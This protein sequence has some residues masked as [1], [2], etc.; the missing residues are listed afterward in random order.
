[1]KARM[2]VAAAAVLFVGMLTVVPA[3]AQ[4]VGGQP[5]SA[6]PVAGPTAGPTLQ[7]QK[8]TPVDVQVGHRTVRTSGFAFTG[9]DIAQIALIAG[10]LVLGGA[11]L[12]RQGRRR[13]V[14]SAS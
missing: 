11:V 13:V 5:P 9:A 2:V 6:G 1:M 10:G 12:V 4:Y 8:V 3:S 14:R 7:V